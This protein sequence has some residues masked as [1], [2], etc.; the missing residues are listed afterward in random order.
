MLRVTTIVGGAS[1]TALIPGGDLRLSQTTPASFPPCGA[2]ACHVL[3][4]DK[5]VITGNI[6]LINNSFFIQQ[7][8]CRMQLSAMT[9]ENIW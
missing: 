6:A 1:F 7:K 3:P 2:T 9:P 4:P 5:T 8:E